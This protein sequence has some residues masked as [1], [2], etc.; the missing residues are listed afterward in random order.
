MSVNPAMFVPGMALAGAVQGVLQAIHVQEET[1]R[2]IVT[3]L[4]EYSEALGQSRPGTIRESAYGGSPVGESL[5]H[6]TKLAHDHVFTAMTEMM[7]TLSGT[8]EKVRAYHDE[9]VF[10]DEDVADRSRTAMHRHGLHDPAAGRGPVM[11][12]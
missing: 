6:H 11:E 1:I 7:N 4:E 2:E 8:G 12:A 5:G 3:I 10:Q 9:I